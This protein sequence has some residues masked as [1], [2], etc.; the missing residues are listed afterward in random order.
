MESGSAVRLE[1]AADC[2]SAPS[3]PIAS[4]SA[5]EA[6]AVQMRLAHHASRAL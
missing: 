1:Q 4:G 5:V 3:W 6:R 2:V